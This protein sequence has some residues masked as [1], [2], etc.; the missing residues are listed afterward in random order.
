MRM[1]MVGSMALALA[2]AWSCDPSSQP[3]S[4]STDV[5]LERRWS[6]QAWTVDTLLGGVND[7]I[8]LGPAGL[9]ANGRGLYWFD[10]YAKQVLHA[11]SLGNVSWTFGRPGGGPGE[12]QTIRG[13]SLAPDG[14]VWV[15]DPDNQR[16]TVI[17]EAGGLTEELS[18]AALEGR[19]DRIA[20]LADGR[21]LL[22]VYGE[23]NPLVIMEGERVVEKLPLPD[24][25]LVD[26]HPLV[27][28]LIL[29]A[30]D[31]QWVAALVSGP[32]FFMGDGDSITIHAYPEQVTLPDVS[33]QSRNV[34]RGSQ[35][36]TRVA[37]PTPAAISL[38]QTPTELWI[39]F[40]GETED[41]NRIVDRYDHTTGAYRGSHLLPV[42]MS[43]IA[44]QGESVFALSSTQYPALLRLDPRLQRE[45]E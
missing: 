1:S 7:T 38:T 3:R 24:P 27:R 30:C 4:Y 36:V 16:V 9:T 6:E 45:P 26:A 12:F 43:H 37:R 33:R 18:L 8:L 29:E 21:Y 11:D 41:R 44:I 25:E 13:L 28:Q 22:Y 32:E 15:L 39:L 10:T 17:S 23:R 14:S 40:G 19:P 5:A 35:T 2:V 20:V 31:G 42:V 34:A